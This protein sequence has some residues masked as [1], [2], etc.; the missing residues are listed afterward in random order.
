MSASRRDDLGS[1]SSKKR[2]N[3]DENDDEPYV[4]SNFVEEASDRIEVNTD[5]IKPAIAEQ[6]SDYVAAIAGDSNV[7]EEM[8][9]LTALIQDKIGMIKENKRQRKEESQLANDTAQYNLLTA[10]G[11][12]ETNRLIMET[13]A[14][15]AIKALLN[16]LGPNEDIK[17]NVLDAMLGVCKNMVFQHA[18]WTDRDPTLQGKFD[19]FTNSLFEHISSAASSTAAATASVVSTT[20]LPLSA[21]VVVVM[22][23]IYAGTP[24]VVAACALAYLGYQ[25][26][27][28]LAQKGH[29]TQEWARIGMNNCIDATATVLNGTCYLATGTI[30]GAANVLKKTVTNIARA[31]TNI[32]Q[33]GADTAG[34]AAAIYYLMKEFDCEAS[35]QGSNS[36]RSSNSSRASSISQGILQRGVVPSGTP[37][38][39]ILNGV[40]AIEQGPVF[41]PATGMELDDTMSTQNSDTSSNLGMEPYKK[42]DEI[43]GGRRRRGRRSRRYKKRRS[44]LKRRRMKRR[45]TR[46]GKKR[47]HTKRRR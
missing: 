40:L 29:L 11:D 16:R 18:N 43:D 22:S 24:P 15:P 33:T 41:N 31:G 10:F 14:F 17:K 34:A 27:E 19:D 3:D 1:A 6:I 37:A 44:T 4:P 12:E 32:V 9:R 21:S 36:P 30:V 47:R 46:K 2:G 38:A 23:A 26:G 45:R 7:A 39:Q 20:A 13:G 35:S 42:M 8:I 25:G 28:I 5:V